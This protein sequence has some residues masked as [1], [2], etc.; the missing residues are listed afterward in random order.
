MKK[1]LCFLSALAV[2]V[3]AVIFAPDIKQYADDYIAANSSVDWEEFSTEPSAL[4]SKYKNH[5]DALCTDQKKAYNNILGAVLTCEEQFPDEIEVPMMTGD[6]LTAVFEAVVYDNPSILCFGTNCSIITRGELCYFKPDYTMTVG[7]FKQKLSQLESKTAE[8][9]G[10]IPSGADEYEKELFIHDY[11]VSNCTYD[12]SLSLT[13]GMIYSCIID[14]S[15]ACEGYAKSAKYMLEK[16][17][18]E[19]YT[20]VGKA[21]NKNGESENHMWNIVRIGGEYY[22]L[23]LTWDDPAG[24]KESVSHTYMNLTEQEIR[25]DHFEFY[26][27]FECKSTAANYF[28]KS[29]LLFDS[30]NSSDYKTLQKKL[31]QNALSSKNRIEIRFT[32]DEAFDSGYDRLITNAS[33]YYLAKNINRQNDT[34]LNEKNIEYTKDE[35]FRVIELIFE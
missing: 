21:R 5:F 24:E 1:F 32:S 31:A 8:V 33:A 34:S 29:G 12:D 27:Y 14:G 11:I 19:C 13:S 4:G 20:V 3:C 28:K 10:K 23:D 30:F 9:L 15:A 22:H 2:I 16:A 18:L 25:L 35:N 17:G 26:S 7:E 6:E